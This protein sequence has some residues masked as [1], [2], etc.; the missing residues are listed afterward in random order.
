LE[1]AAEGRADVDDLKTRLNEANVSVAADLNAQ[2]DL[3]RSFA[4]EM[5]SLLNPPAR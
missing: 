2:R 4:R 5:D 1:R 3:I